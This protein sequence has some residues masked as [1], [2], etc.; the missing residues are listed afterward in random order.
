MTNAR[1]YLVGETGF[2]GTI[3]FVRD[4]S[5]VNSRRTSYW[6]KSWRYAQR[7][8]MKAAATRVDLLRNSSS[9]TE[10][11]YWWAHKKDVK[12]KVVKS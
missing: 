4:T 7:F 11:R 3:F 1:D 5:R 2:D 6:T 8:N 12:P 9:F 10:D